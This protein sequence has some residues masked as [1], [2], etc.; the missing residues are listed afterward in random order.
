MSVLVQPE[1]EVAVVL[2]GDFYMASVLLEQRL[3][4]A[5]K[6][7]DEVV[8]SGLVRESE[9]REIGEREECCKWERCS[10]SLSPGMTGC[11][12]CLRHAG[13]WGSFAGE[14]LTARSSSEGKCDQ[15]LCAAV[16]VPYTCFSSP[17]LDP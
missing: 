5:G 9:A 16:T 10:P 6:R 4:S 14:N 17:S 7:S 15:V 12:M 3:R 2:R 8:G 11:L 13:P 1:E